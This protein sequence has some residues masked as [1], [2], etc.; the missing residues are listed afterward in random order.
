MAEPADLNRLLRPRSIAV[1]GDSRAS[2]RVI[3]Q[4]RRLGFRGPTL[5]GA[6]ERHLV[7]PGSRRSLGSPT[8]RGV[9]DAAF[10]AVP[11]PA[12]AA[13]VAELAA[14]GCGAAVVYS[15]GFAE[16]GAGRRGAAARADRCGRVDAAARAELLRA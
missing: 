15:S 4:N 14:A 11:A 7:S 1:I 10:V 9:P 3:E 12:C 2:G 13:V 16:T 5:A 6:P 8:C